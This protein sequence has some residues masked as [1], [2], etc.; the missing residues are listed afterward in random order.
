M[1]L[2]WVRQDL[3]PLHFP[4]LWGETETYM[5]KMEGKERERERVWEAMAP[6]GIWR[7]FLCS[8]ATQKKA[9]SMKLT[10]SR[11]NIWRKKKHRERVREI[12]LGFWK[13]L[14]PLHHSTIL[15]VN[16]KSIMHE[17]HR[18]CEHAL[19]LSPYSTTQCHPAIL[20]ATQHCIA[21]EKRGSMR[22]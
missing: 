2:F 11:I 14:S 8:C 13:G 9:T 20:S 19:W 3:Y 15:P 22:G 6:W 12:R 7:I 16:T 21:Q 4:N 5:W 1:L 18:V 10:V 17:A